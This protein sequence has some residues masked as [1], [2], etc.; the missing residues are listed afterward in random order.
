M[1]SWRISG[2]DLFV[3]FDKGLVVVRFPRIALPRPPWMD[4]LDVRSQNPRACHQLA[5]A[6]IFLSRERVKRV[7]KGVANALQAII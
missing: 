5:C 1:K 4:V 6:S 2:S 3:G 7:T